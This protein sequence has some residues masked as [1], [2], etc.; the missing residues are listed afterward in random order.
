MVTAVLDSACDQG[1]ERECNRYCR[2]EEEATMSDR[3]ADALR[4]LTLLCQFAYENGFHELGYNPLDVLAARVAAS[5]EALPADESASIKS[6]HALILNRLHEMQRAPYYATARD[7]L[8]LAESTIV[9]LERR[10]A[11]LEYHEDSRC[12]WED[13]DQQAVYCPGHAQELW[14]PNMDALAARIAELESVAHE[15][16]DKPVEIW[17]GE[18]KVSIYRDSVVRS[19]GSN[20][21]TEMSDEPR[22]L[23]S[24]QRSV[25]WLYEPPQPPGES[26]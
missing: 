1:Y 21:D 26:R 12:C 15:P 18:R 8:A 20:I 4:D 24:V 5:N 6:A 9:Q 25:D 17:Q 10:V 23:D 19:W 14:Q 16:L 22:T 13:C 3:V 11:E 7:E 2:V